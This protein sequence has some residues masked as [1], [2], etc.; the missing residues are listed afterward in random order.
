[1][2]LADGGFGRWWRCNF[3][4]GVHIVKIII[5]L[6]ERCFMSPDFSPGDQLLNASVYLVSLVRSDFIRASNTYRRS[7]FGHL[8]DKIGKVFPV[9]V[10]DVQQM[11]PRHMR[12]HNW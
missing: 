8:G 6:L 5:N 7:T 10:A 9:W 3:I 1:V 12:A 4:W 11:F 2:A